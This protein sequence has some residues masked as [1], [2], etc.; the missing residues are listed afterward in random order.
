MNLLQSKAQ[1]VYRYIYSHPR[2]LDNMIKHLNQK[3]VSEIL[4]KLLNLNEP[5]SP[6]KKEASQ[7]ES[8]LPEIV[9][10]LRQSYVYKIVQRIVN[11]EETDLEVFLNGISVLQELVFVKVINQELSS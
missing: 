9:D 3:S 6:S 1:E 5:I 4:Q 11:A 7:E 10:G 2:V 8:L